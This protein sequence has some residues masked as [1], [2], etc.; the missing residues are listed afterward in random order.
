[1][2]IFYLVGFIVVWFLV[3]MNCTLRSLWRAWALPM[4]KGKTTH[5]QWMR[6]T[7]WYFMRSSVSLMLM[8]LN[9]QFCKSMT[10]QTLDPPPFIT[11]MNRSPLPWIFW[12]WEEKGSAADCHS[13]WLQMLLWGNI[14]AHK[15]CTQRM[16]IKD[17]DRD[18]DWPTKNPVLDNV[19]ENWSRERTDAIAFTSPPSCNSV[20]K[21]EIWNRQKRKREAWERKQKIDLFLKPTE[22]V[23][24]C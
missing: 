3:A 9:S 16:Y 18:D 12:Q 19:N 6:A 7:S 8:P 14:K 10:L 4:K 13:L 24:L 2:G 21:P 15:V 22:V 17:G 20:A 11:E 23:H 1:M 5:C